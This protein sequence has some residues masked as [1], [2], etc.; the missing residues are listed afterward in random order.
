MQLTWV[1]GYVVIMLVNTLTFLLGYWTG[2]GFP[3]FMR[4]WVEAPKPV[5]LSIPDPLEAEMEELRRKQAKLDADRV[6]QM[7]DA[8]NWNGKDE[9]ESVVSNDD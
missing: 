8:L 3:A 6:K 9:R 7:F 2:V 1:L 4:K 5:V